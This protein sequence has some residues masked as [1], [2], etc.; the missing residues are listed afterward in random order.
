GNGVGGNGAS[1]GG[2][3]HY[4]QAS[5]FGPFGHNGHT[6]RGE[7]GAQY[8]PGGWAGEAQDNQHAQW[9]QSHTG[10][11]QTHQTQPHQVQAHQ[12]AQPPQHPQ[13]L[14]HEPCYPPQAGAG[15]PGE[16]SLNAPP[17]EKKRW[18]TGAVAALMVGAVVLAS[19]TTFALSTMQGTNSTR[20]VNTL[21][22]APTGNEDTS[23]SRL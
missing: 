19:G 14:P 1:G 8:G 10:Y 22:S 2:G 9:G 11:T 21:D 4:P 17:K 12:G 23:S 6:R 16:N 5:D 7:A 15:E 18:S 20:S 13:A 3:E